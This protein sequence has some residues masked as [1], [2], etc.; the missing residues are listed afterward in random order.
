MIYLGR[1]TEDSKRHGK[2]PWRFG[3]NHSFLCY[4]V[5]SV[6]IQLNTCLFGEPQKTRKDTERNLGGSEGELDFPRG[7]VDSV[8]IYM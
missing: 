3:G 2:E 7:F 5:D 6:V 1:T 8:V 4:F